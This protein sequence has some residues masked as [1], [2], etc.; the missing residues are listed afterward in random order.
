MT[1]GEHSAYA[2]LLRALQ[3]HMMSHHGFSGLFLCKTVAAWM[4]PA[5][6]N[7]QTP[8]LVSRYDLH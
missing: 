1:T 5:M 3:E 6:A 7:R 8:L 2:R 4:H